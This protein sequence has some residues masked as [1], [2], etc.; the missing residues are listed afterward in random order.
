MPI[1]ND[2]FSEKYY[3]G[4]KKEKKNVFCHNLSP[5]KH[6]SWSPY[7]SKKSKKIRP[8]R[9]E[10]LYKKNISNFRP[11]ST[12]ML[13]IPSLPKPSN[14]SSTTS[15]FRTFRSFHGYLPQISCRCQC[16]P[17]SD[18]SIPLFLLVS[19]AL[20]PSVY[21]LMSSTYVLLITSLPILGHLI[22]LKIVPFC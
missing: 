4:I 12:F 13:P 19:Y 22:W 8:W 17:T 18:A 5:R 10:A 6:K 2:F 16:E 1:C 11:M 20:F 21:L 15:H 3:L 7:I 14:Q 9:Q